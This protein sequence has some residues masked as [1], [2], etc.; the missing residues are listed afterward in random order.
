M[1]DELLQR[2]ADLDPV[3]E[4]DF[5]TQIGVERD[6]YGATQAIEKALY[7]LRD[8]AARIEQLTADKRFIVEERD[9]TFALMLA[10]A[11]KAEA[12]RDRL[13]KELEN[14]VADCEADYP[15]SHGAIKYAARAALK[16][17]TP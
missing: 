14:I 2:L 10:H 15:P 11:E 17:E 9:R 3:L 13:R 4:T 8:Q 12:E 1:T 7:L 16:G 5:D 6:P